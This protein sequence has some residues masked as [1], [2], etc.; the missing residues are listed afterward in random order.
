MKWQ[1][2]NRSKLH[3]NSN[4]S[5][6]S[7][8]TKAKVSIGIFPTTFSSCFD[9]INIKNRCNSHYTAHVTTLISQTTEAIAVASINYFKT[10]VLFYQYLL[11]KATYTRFRHFVFFKATYLL[12]SA[13]YIT[14]HVVHLEL[15]SHVFRC[16]CMLTHGWL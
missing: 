14:I 8:L 12:P 7:L 15:I 6:E 1:Q 3:A 13:E 5:T 4:Q 10:T 16:F 2:P 9:T 11:L